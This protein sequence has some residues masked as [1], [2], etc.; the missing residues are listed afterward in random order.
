MKH[1]VA[2][3]L[4]LGAA[5]GVV[6]LT[7]N[8]LYLLLVALVSFSVA[9]RSP[10][11]PLWLMLPFAALF[12]ALLSH[13]GET[14]LLRLPLSGVPITA[15]ALAYGAL[16]GL[17]LF[18]LFAIF[19]TFNTALR[20]RDLL[21]LTPRAFYSL[22]LS[23]TIALTYLPLL[24]RQV[25][26]I[27]EA[28]RLRG[29][30]MRGWRAWTPL[31]LPLLIG[32]LERAF[33]L[34]EALA[35]RGYIVPAP[36]RTWGMTVGLALVLSGLLGTVVTPYAAVALL[37]GLG[38]MTWDLARGGRAVPA[39]PLSPNPWTARDSMGVAGALAALA[40]VALD[41]ARTYLPYPALSWPPFT[42]WAGLALL[43]LLAAG[44][45]HD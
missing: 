7:R 40:L 38:L 25:Q 18:T 31:L 16:N 8:P 6:L 39:R 17:V 36:H 26:A 11:S 29:A 35:V 33:A 45:A 21:A 14:V 37:P 30:P 28:Q 12:N 32:S 4:W 13:A 44:G 10:F 20:P 2:W 41:P 15:E 34:A 42:P 22:A 23:V 24:R 27:S 19:Q 43:G 3:L 9:R 1:P 5:L